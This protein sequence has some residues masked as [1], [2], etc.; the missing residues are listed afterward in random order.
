MKSDFFFKGKNYLQAHR[1]KFAVVKYS[2]VAKTSLISVS[3][4]A[5]SRHPEA[6]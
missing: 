3:L 5:Y 4:T 6:F 2:R 1:F